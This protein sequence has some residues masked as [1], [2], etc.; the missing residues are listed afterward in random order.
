MRIKKTTGTVRALGLLLALCLMISVMGVSALAVD[1]ERSCTVK[2][3]STGEESSEYA[4]DL[5]GADLVVDVYQVGAVTPLVIDEAEYDAIQYNLIAPYDGIEIPEVT[6]ADTWANLAQ[7]AA[8]IALG[9]E[10]KPMEGMTG[11]SIENTLSL[12]AGLYLILARGAALTEKADYVVNVGEN[13]EIA[14]KASTAMYDYDFAPVLLTLPTK[15]AVEG[16]ITTD[17]PGDWLYENIAVNLKP[18]RTQRVGAFDIVKYLLTYEDSNADD[19]KEPV[20]FVFTWTATL[21][22]TLIAS[23]AESLVFTNA[24]SKYA[25]VNNIPVGAVVTV[26][27]VYSD[28]YE[29]VGMEPADG[30]VVVTADVEQPVKV[31]F[32]ND[33]NGPRPHGTSVANHFVSSGDGDW[34]WSKLPDTSE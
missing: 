34:P 7:Q 9:E 33:Y 6:D 26:E 29:L 15:E 3:N 27:E 28:G 18:E 11:V 21:D 22:G 25:R 16:V 8:E 4:E 19:S 13:N 30:T 10:G 31:E 12:P 24:G 5:A 17:A 14:T 20:T 32:E 1:V 2:V 23:G